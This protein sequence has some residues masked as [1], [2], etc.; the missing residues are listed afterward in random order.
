MRSP[1]RIAVALAA[2]SVTILTLAC[3]RDTRTALGPDTNML[4]ARATVA[5]AAGP[6][7]SVG[8]PGFEYTFP[9]GG[10]T[11]PPLMVEYSARGPTVPVWWSA[12]P[13]PDAT[14]VA[15]R[16]AI[17]IEDIL[18]ETPRVDEATD[19]RH[20]S[21]WSPATVRARVSRL[22]PAP[23]SPTRRLY[24]EARDTNGLVSLV[25]VEIDFMA[26]RSSPHPPLDDDTGLHARPEAAASTAA[27]TTD[28]GAERR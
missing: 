24:I 19:L 5:E 4:L 2:T 18:D 12:T 21:T 10:V 11:D 6:V 13:S 20:W 9:D 8:A 14:I 17:D 25:A 3:S 22:Q 23:P 7:F 15:Y 16:W 28:E 1:I 26:G 27:G